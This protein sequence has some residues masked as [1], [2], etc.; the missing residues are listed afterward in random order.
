MAKEQRQFS[1]RP[2][3]TLP[4]DRPDHA[5]IANQSGGGQRIGRQQQMIEPDGLLL[6]PLLTPDLAPLPIDSYNTAA[7]AD[8]HT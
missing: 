4:L 2:Q 1:A 3:K 6:A 7:Q 8:V 5:I